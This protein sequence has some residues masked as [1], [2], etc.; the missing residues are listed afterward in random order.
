MSATG[1][2]WVYAEIA[3]L[4][5]HT[6]VRLARGDFVVEEDRATITA[7]RLR[8]EEVV[9]QFGGV[10]WWRFL[11]EEGVYTRHTPHVEHLD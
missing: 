10:P 2:G 8:A 11:E 4:P 9:R 1:G 3:D 5:G 7:S 6:L